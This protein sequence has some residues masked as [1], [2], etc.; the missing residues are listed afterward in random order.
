MRTTRFLNFCYNGNIVRA[1]LSWGICEYPAM[2]IFLYYLVYETLVTN[3]AY[4]KYTLTLIWLTLGSKRNQLCLQNVFNL[5]LENLSRLRESIKC[6]Y[7]DWAAKLS[8]CLAFRMIWNLFEVI[9]FSCFRR[10]M[11]GEKIHS[12]PLLNKDV[13]GCPQRD[14]T[15]TG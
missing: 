14:S 10:M 12:T 13:H 6:M 7:L 9:F 2:S 11:A 5:L 3:D 8:V 15:I 4:A 1:V